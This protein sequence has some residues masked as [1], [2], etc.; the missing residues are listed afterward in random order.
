MSL[1]RKHWDLL[2]ETEVQPLLILSHHKPFGHD[3]NTVNSVRVQERVFETLVKSFPDKFPLFLGQPI[4]QVLHVRGL[5]GPPIGVLLLSP[6]DVVS[7]D[8]PD[9]FPVFIENP[10]ELQGELWI[11]ESTL[12]CDVTEIRVGAE[13]KLDPCFQVLPTVLSDHGATSGTGN[14]GFEAF[15]G[16][17]LGCHTS[18][19]ALLKSDP[20]LT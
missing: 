3:W 2:F 9:G 13:V 17:I 1:E 11:D 6:E 8:S 20:I 14:D 10:L 12:S 5:E 18:S 15:G 4:L 19:V 16:F 7:V